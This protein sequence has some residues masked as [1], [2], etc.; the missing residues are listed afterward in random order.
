MMHSQ[1]IKLR[2]TV[3]NTSGKINCSRFCINRLLDEFHLFNNAAILYEGFQWYLRVF[4]NL[5]IS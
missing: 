2:F 3:I 5:V 1:N 4:V